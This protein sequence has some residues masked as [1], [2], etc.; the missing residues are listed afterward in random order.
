M[1]NVVS[2]R[3]TNEV[4]EKIKALS[5]SI[6]RETGATVKGAEVFRMAIERGIA[7]L[8]KPNVLESSTN[9]EQ[10]RAADVAVELV[11]LGRQKLM[12]QC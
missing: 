4:L 5:E 11:N 8:E 7:T 6:S 2:L 12:E 10:I 3:V 1:K 9:Y